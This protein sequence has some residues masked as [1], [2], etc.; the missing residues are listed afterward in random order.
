MKNTLYV[1][2]CLFFS[3]LLIAQE[4]GKYD[5]L[6]ILY[7]DAKY[8]KVIATAEKY[9]QKEDNKKDAE[10]YMWMAKAFYKISLSGTIPE[11]FQ[12]SYKSASKSLAKAFKLD[13]DSTCFEKNDDFIYEFQAS[14][15]ERL[16]NDLSSEEY[17]KASG[18]AQQ[19]SKVTYYSVGADLLV[20]SV[21]FRSGDKTGA[22]T[23]LAKCDQ[24]IDLIDNLAHW[25]DSDVSIFKH[26]VIQAAECYVA[27]RHLEKAQALLDKVIG[28]YLDDE[29]FNLRLKEILN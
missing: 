17:K 10:P 8:E 6:V 29:E 4:E 15:E 20:A 23:L 13:K 7:A 3:S 28:W 12:N 26:G 11:G 14:I 19:Y 1:L 5:D 9:C 2:I 18:W 27:A 25:S 16:L 24:Q 21:K 22:K